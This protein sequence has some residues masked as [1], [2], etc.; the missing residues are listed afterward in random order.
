M[1]AAAEHG[2]DGDRAAAQLLGLEAAA[3]GHE[4]QAAQLLGD[5]GGLLGGGVD[6]DDVEVA[7]DVGGDADVDA[8]EEV[9]G[10]VVVG[11]EAVEVR[12]CALLDAEHR[13]G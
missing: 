6:D 8:L 11:E 2:G 9:Q 7:L 10:V 4:L 1:Y 13:Q 5:G 3:Q 12:V